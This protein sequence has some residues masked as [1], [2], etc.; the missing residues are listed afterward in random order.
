MKDVPSRQVRLYFPFAVMLAVNAAFF[1]LA[2]ILDN[3]SDVFSGF[4]KIVTS[5]SILVTDYIEIGGIG[6][7]LLN[8]SLVG[9][10][11]VLIFVFSGA[12][13]NGAIIMAMWMTVGFAFFGKNVFNM[14]PLTAGVWLFAKYNKERFIN[15]SLAALLSAT[16]APVI[17]EISF[18]GVFSRPAEIA[19]GVTLGFVIGFIFPAISAETVKAHSGYN[20]YN[21][22]FAGGLIA[23][24]FATG[25]K[26][27]GIDIVP[28]SVWSSG[29]NIILAG[30]LYAISAAMLCCG[31]F[32]GGVKNNID[33]FVKIFRH[34]GRLVTDFYILYKNSIYINMAVLCAFATTL[35]LVLGAEL[36]GPVIAGIFTVAGFGSFGKHLKNII[37]VLI[38]A[39]ISA[40]INQWEPAYPANIMAILFSTCLAPIAG[41]FGWIWGITA[42]FLHVSVAMHVGHLNS[43]LNLY[44]NGFAAGL[45]VMFL[46]P[47]IIALKRDKR[48]K[49]K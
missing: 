29:N 8:V 36:N 21:M 44:N 14:L 2:F 24:I 31:I 1:A 15:Y 48:K 33:G 34:P 9:F 39:V 32:A 43:G 26:S 41:Q 47:V 45:V 35:T 23:T 20:L 30:V 11:S 27:F 22:G 6:A 7:T 5:R 37:P 13:P 12:E 19:A 16:V 4:L 42:G 38:G 10:M 46:L 18:L 3:P 25:F 28:V 17:S 49:N 40:Y